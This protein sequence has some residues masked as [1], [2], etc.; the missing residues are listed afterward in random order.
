MKILVLLIVI[1]SVSNS[2]KMQETNSIP[3]MTAENLNFLGVE[4]FWKI[5]D[6]LEK[7]TEPTEAEWN[8]LFNTPGYE[9]LVKIENKG[10]LFKR[11]FPLVFSPSKKKALAKVLENGGNDLY[12]LNHY[13]KLKS[14]R[15]AMFD[16]QDK[17]AKL[18]LL[19]IILQTKI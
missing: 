14:Q 17:I 19:S 12:Y 2:F 4:A 11:L 8:M 1:L 6:L 9:Y 16:Y 15:G 10:N 3:K 7:D 5:V 13:L 18:N